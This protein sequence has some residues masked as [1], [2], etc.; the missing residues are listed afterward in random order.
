M[1][2]R[3]LLIDLDSQASL[4]VSFFTQNEWTDELLPTRTIKHW[5]DGLSTGDAMEDPTRCCRPRRGCSASCA[6]APG[7]ST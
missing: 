4:T 6:A 7:T 1:A 2:Q 5:Y 3:V